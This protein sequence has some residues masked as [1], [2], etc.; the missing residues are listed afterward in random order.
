MKANRWV[1]LGAPGVGKGT[2]AKRLA[3]A[4]GWIHISTGDML[5]EAM[6]RE[7]GL[8]KKVKSYVEKG[9]LVP[10]DLMVSLVRERLGQSDCKM[11][12]ILDGF[13]RTQVQA[14]R[15]NEVLKELRMELNGVISIEVPA[16]E[17]IRRLSMRRIC[18]SC[19]NID[20]GNKEGGKG[21]CVKCGGKLIRRK[22]DEPETIRHRLNV[23]ERSTQSLIDY[24]K[25][26]GMLL[27]VDGVG[28]MD[29]VYQRIVE[30]VIPSPDRP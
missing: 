30:T 1:I 20:M 10:D 15:L 7:S 12:F 28:S 19:G 23:Y 29:E 27:P 8:G 5:R 9:D 21:T 16:R 22:D 25:N 3:G 18:Q 11:G 14:E 4:F 24:Y 6:G 17:I 2:Q 13:P 26:L